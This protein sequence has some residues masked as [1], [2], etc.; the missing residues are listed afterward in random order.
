[1]EQDMRRISSSTTLRRHIILWS[2]PLAAVLFHLDFAHPFKTPKI[3]ALMPMLLFLLTSRKGRASLSL[4]EALLVLWPIATIFQSV[5]LRLWA[6]GLLTTLFYG[7]ALM[8]SLDEDDRRNLRSGLAISSIPVVLYLLIQKAGWDPI[9]FHEGPEAGSFL[10]NVNFAAHY[11][12]L[13]LCLGNF[14]KSRWRH[15][16][17]VLIIIGVALTRSR[18]VWFM[19][20]LFFA[21]SLHQ[22]RYLKRALL[23]ILIS[24]LGAAFIWRVDVG[25]GLWWATHAHAYEKAYEKQPRPN[26][27]PP[28]PDL[29]EPWFKGKRFSLMTRFLLMGNSLAA[30]VDHGIIGAGM[31]QFHVIY[32]L[33]SR[34][35]VPDVNMNEVY[36]ASSAHNLVLDG[37]IAFGAP[38]LIL[39]GFYLK[40]ILAREKGRYSLT[41]GLHL[42]IALVSLNYLNPLIVGLFILLRPRRETLIEERSH[43]PLGLVM[44]GLIFLLG[45]W[46]LKAGAQTW[47]KPAF[48]F[49][50]RI[51]AKHYDRGEVDQ[52]WEWQIKA[53]K[54]D[55]YGPETLFNLGLAAWES[56]KEEGDS[57]QQIALE[58]FLLVRK[59]YPHYRPAQNH[60]ETLKQQGFVIDA[61]REVSH[62]SLFSKLPH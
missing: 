3:L 58:S 42:G 17:Y 14:G 46:D 36:R 24:G 27:D 26:P 13:C 45:L 12:L 38:W 16:A 22:G 18:A 59:L 51:A 55:P 32:P 56:S 28:A 31:G 7:L 29:R 10:G 60:L 47:T 6:D 4:F 44:A 1:M 30:A 2:A 49:P 54:Q 5:N 15:V 37:M 23:T 43:W 8:V 11:L 40:K 52:A 62:Q 21:Y 53:V 35:V 25:E 57:R 9:N 33:Y 50:E 39:L 20:L 48:L 61:T 19:T 34:S 41:L